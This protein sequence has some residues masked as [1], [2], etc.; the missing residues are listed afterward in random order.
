MGNWEPAGLCTGGFSLIRD[1]KN[2]TTK[3]SK[4]FSPQRSRRS[5]SNTY[6]YQDGPVKMMATGTNN[7]AGEILS[8]GAG[9]LEMLPIATHAWIANLEEFFVGFVVNPSCELFI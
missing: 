3:F 1:Q 4:S 8:Y 5:Q 7:S 6:G 9:K 2:S